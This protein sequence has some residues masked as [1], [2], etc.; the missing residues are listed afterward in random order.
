MRPGHVVRPRRATVHA[1]A[2]VL[3]ILVA[4]CTTTASGPGET[5]PLSGT[6]TGSM[7]GPLPGVTVTATP[8]G[9]MPLTATTASNGTYSMPA[10][11]IGPG[12]IVV[13][14]VPTTCTAP[15]WAGRRVRHDGRPGDD[16]RRQ[17][18]G[19]QRH[20]VQH[21]VGVRLAAAAKHGDRHERRWLLNRR[22]RCRQVR[23]ADV[24]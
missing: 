7:I 23:D 1:L 3:A 10:V 2:S 5:E 21:D 17:R 13:S 18:R 19:E 20:A 15:A 14:A 16:D 4:A 9:Q 11:P 8:S 24:G 6:V 22:P 12:S